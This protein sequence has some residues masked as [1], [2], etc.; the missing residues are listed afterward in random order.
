MLSNILHYIHIKPFE[1]SY[2]LPKALFKINLSPHST[3]GNDF[4]LLSYTRP[5]GQFI[6]TFS[7]NKSRVHI[8]T[9]E[10]THTPIHI[11]FLEREIKTHIGRENHEI[12]LQR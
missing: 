3:L 12:V 2:T 6:D 10:P 7:L 4:H 5:F 11:I 1:Q 9:D 8:K